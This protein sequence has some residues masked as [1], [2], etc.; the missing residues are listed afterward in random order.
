MFDALTEKIR[1]AI[2]PLRQKGKIRAA[3]LAATIRKIKL[4]LL[5]ADVHYR[6][7]QD[8]I[9]R[10]SERLL[11]QK[12]LPTLNP[13]QQILAT[14]QQEIEELLGGSCSVDFR[15]TL[16][17]GLQGSGK[18]TT[19]AKLG[20]WLKKNQRGN[21]LL[22]PADTRRPAAVEQLKRLGKK[23]RI[24]VFDAPTT[25][26]AEK[27]CKQVVAAHADKN[28]IID[29]AGR[30]QMD[31]PLMRELERLIKIAKPTTKLLVVDAMIGQEAC[32]IAKSFHNE[33]GL[34]GIV[35]TKME[36]D[37]RG[38]AALSMRAVTGVPI[39]FLGTGEGIDTLERFDAASIAGR[40]LGMGDMRALLER[41]KSVIDNES[42]VDVQELG[43]V[44]EFTL[45]SFL[46]L[47]RMLS[48]MGPVAE[49]LA[50]IPGFSK[51]S[52]GLDLSAAEATRKRVEAM[53][54]SMT[55]EER[56]NPRI[57][58]A[59][60]RQRIAAGSGTSVPELN[61][62]LKQYEQMKKLLQKQGAAALFKGL[63][64]R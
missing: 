60:R 21:P 49:M 31:Q 6:V 43:N 51:V 7:V 59:S 35:L 30:L 18:T 44:R 24:D 8:L 15:I 23:H 38:G 17:I 25:S 19:A 57:L 10:V 58:N 48:R 29:S 56:G 53:I 14:I 63:A 2:S 36:G 5:E 4:S 54:L 28:L 34:D 26:G 46:K 50:M 33:C 13:E 41:S 11:N 3:D 39:L 12:V 16:L 47:N 55:L 9:T 64:R 32:N 62:F 42:A 37:A 40:I 61:R 1:S 27:I 22:V 20:H 52:K 45:N